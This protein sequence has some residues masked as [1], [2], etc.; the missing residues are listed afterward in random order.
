MLILELFYFNLDFTV[1]F[2][3]LYFFLSVRLI[4]KRSIELFADTKY[5]EISVRL[6]VLK[7][8]PPF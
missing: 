8:L 6:V 5:F 1:H 4:V 7:G 3:E 2:S